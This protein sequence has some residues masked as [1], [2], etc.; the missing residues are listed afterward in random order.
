[1]GSYVES[2]HASLKS[3]GYYPGTHTTPID[4]RIDVITHWL[5]ISGKTLYSFFRTGENSIKNLE[6][7]SSERNANS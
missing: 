6:R 5:Y 1:M 2:I 3:Q 4:K 7:L